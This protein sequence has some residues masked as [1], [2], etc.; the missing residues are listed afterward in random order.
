M[1]ER[2]EPRDICHQGTK[3]RLPRLRRSQWRAGTKDFILL[4][5]FSVLVPWWQEKKVNAEFRSQEIML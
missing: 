4:F 2:L 1:F 3:T 5:F